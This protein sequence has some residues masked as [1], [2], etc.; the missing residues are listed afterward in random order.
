[1]IS[2]VFIALLGLLGYFI[3][4]K[5]IKI[6]FI[7][8]AIF[9]LIGVLSIILKSLPIFTPVNQGFLGF[10]FFYVVMITGVF[11]HESNVFRSLCSVRS[12]YSIL[13]FIILTPHAIIYLIE[14]LANNGQF[15][16][17]GVIAYLIMIPLFITSFQNVEN[18]Q[19]KFKWKKLQRYAYFAY[20]FIFIHLIIVAEIPNI[21][22]YLILFIPYFVYKPYHFIKHELPVY[23][24]MQRK[25][26]QTEK[27]KE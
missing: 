8:Y 5:I 13:G 24:A 11:K 19:T 17:M 27:E 7:L 21:I 23:K 14:K 15:E 4:S 9:G 20:L 2:T 16:I 22:V 1:M 18:L 10:S 25:I 26:R 3:S 6:K 12:I